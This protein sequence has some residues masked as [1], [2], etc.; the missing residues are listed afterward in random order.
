VASTHKKRRARQPR[1]EAAAPGG[2][3]RVELK[4]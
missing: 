3:V 4:S 2:M 1:S